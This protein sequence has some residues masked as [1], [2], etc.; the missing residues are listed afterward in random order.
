MNIRFLETL[1]WL[2]RLKSFSK[3][4]EK[5]NTTQPAI[6]SRMS[7]LEE[8]VGCE[9]YVRQA[10]EFELTSH[11]RQIL[12]YAERIVGLSDEL[13]RISA[14]VPDSMAE[15]RMGIIEIG[16]LSWLKRFL[17]SFQEDFPSTTLRITTGT[18]STMLKDL[19]E[20]TIDIAF[21]V[22]PVNEPHVHSDQI[23]SFAIEW[24][25]NP[26][27]FSCDEEIDVVELSHKPIIMYGRDSSA[28]NTISQYFET[29]GIV[30]LPMRHR[31]VVLDCVYSA[32]SGAHAVRE[33]LGVM[34]LPSFLFKADV[35]AGHFAPMRVR[36]KIPALN[37]TACYKQ[38]RTE[39][40]MR[41]IVNM[42]RDSASAF[43]KT[44][45]E[46]HFWI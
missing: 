33:G 36:Q 28:S 15:L 9:L 13:L 18:T 38:A 39:F 16:T 44:Q 27:V 4:A 20:D 41:R 1:I 12:A 42:A 8:W 24:H 32:W 25:A 31:K 21:V 29:Y 35:E 26:N 45:D 23:C 40:P 43:A 10:R 19:R 11:G 37:L 6:S 7:K 3:T 5:L 46:N 34:P 17:E 22:G 2:T 30:D 14:A